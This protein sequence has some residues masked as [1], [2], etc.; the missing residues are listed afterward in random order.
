MHLLF[1][2]TRAN[3]SSNLLRLFGWRKPNVPHKGSKGDLGR[4]AQSTKRLGRLQFIGA[5]RTPPFDRA[6]CETVDFNGRRRCPPTIQASACQEELQQGGHRGGPRVKKGLMDILDL[7]ALSL[8]CSSCGSCYQVPLKQVLLSQD[9]LRQGC[10]VIEESECPPVVYARLLDRELLQQL[11]ELWR[12]LEEKARAAG[13]EL[14]LTNRKLGIRS[15]QPVLARSRVVSAATT[16][17]N[18]ESTSLPCVGTPLRR[19]ASP[20]VSVRSGRAGDFS[21]RPADSRRSSS[22]LA[23]WRGIPEC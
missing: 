23:C 3:S 15:C 20:G 12:S 6:R 8:G 14:V 9:M 2:P 13:G 22:W 1:H 7:T 19:N 18:R 10:P 5:E 11:Q 21:W 17:I 4:G 16:G